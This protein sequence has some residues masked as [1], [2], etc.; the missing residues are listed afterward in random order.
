MEFKGFIGQAYHLPHVNVDAQRLINLYNEVI[1]SG[2]GKESRI[3][4]LKNTPGLTRLF[5]IGSGP[6]RL[7]H[8]DGLENDDGVYFQKN[9][10]FVVSGCEVFRFS[11]D[12]VSGW[13]YVNLGVLTTFTGPVSAA[14]SDQDYGV[15]VFCDGSDEN[16]VYHK[17]DAT[18][19]TFS[20]FTTAGYSPVERSTQVRFVDGY[21]IFI[22]K[23]SN[24]FYVSDWAS[25]NV[26]ALSF[27]SAEGDPDNIVA[28]IANHRDLWL[29]NERTVELFSNTG[30]A[31]FPFERVQGGFIENGCLAAFSVAKISGTILWLGRDLSGQGIINA[32]V[33]SQHI[34][35]STHAIEQE[36]KTYSNLKGATAYTYQ[37]G[38][39]SFYVIN[40]D[41]A[42]WVYDLSTKMWHQR[43]FMNSN[44]ALIRQR[45]ECHAFFPT[46][47]VHL[48]GDFESGY[49]YQ[50][51]DD[52]FT[53]DGAE[54]KRLRSAPHISKGMNWLFFSRFQLDIQTGIG[55]DGS[56]LSEGYDPLMMM[57]Y[58]DDGGHSW[59]NERSVSMGK[60]GQRHVRPRWTRLGKS[61]D[62]VFEVSTT[63]PVK[64]IWMGAELDVSI[65]G[66]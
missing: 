14:S 42:T 36:I 49:L 23:D 59:S 50:Y 61:R 54:I 51:D 48:V 6:I 16:Y 21:F 38:G 4:F 55:L 18:T 13:D 45:A 25:L 1:E 5:S 39:H 17:T 11:Y 29:L 56:V 7:I 62:R 8:F 47:G 22:V 12:P 31:D 20:N 28:I 60:I 35:I 58:S 57:R 19:E 15:T 52:V 63:A 64:S 41:E 30:N 65:G 66:N 26:S 3:T 44:G 32:A 40:F 37:D 9:R 33:G 34:R 46:L 10:I 2:S 24:Q 43:A 53:D 27:A